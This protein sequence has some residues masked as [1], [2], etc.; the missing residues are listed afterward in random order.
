MTT[1][2]VAAVLLAIDPTGQHLSDVVKTAAGNFFIAVLAVLGAA[3]KVHDHVRSAALLAVHP[4]CTD[5]PGRPGQARRHEV[6]QAPRLFQRPGDR[7]RLD[8]DGPVESKPLTPCSLVTAQL[9]IVPTLRFACG[10]PIS[11]RY[12]AVGMWADVHL[13]GVLCL[14][15]AQPRPARAAF[16]ETT[17]S[18][19][20]PL[21]MTVKH[22]P[23]TQ[24]QRCGDRTDVCVHVSAFHSTLMYQYSR[25]R[26]RRWPVAPTQHANRPRR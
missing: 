11:R 16:A 17:L 19:R 3:L 13:I 4:P 23:L 9:L 1:Y 15:G 8:S 20:R 26:T 25:G 7:Q 22:E 14:D 5:Q 18:E 6:T 2:V 24:R 10:A 12:R 21:T